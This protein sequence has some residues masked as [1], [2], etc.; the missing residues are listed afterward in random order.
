MEQVSSPKITCDSG[1]RGVVRHNHRRCSH[2]RDH[3]VSLHAVGG[4]HTRLFGGN[5]IHHTGCVWFF[6]CG[7]TL[8]LFGRAG[9][10]GGGPG[11]RQLPFVRFDFSCR[12]AR[13]GA[14]LGVNGVCGQF[15]D[16]SVDR[17][18]RG[19]AAFQGPLAICVARFCLGNARTRGSH[20]RYLCER[21]FRGAISSSAAPDRAS[22]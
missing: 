16:F 17:R 7:R 3:R 10:F 5:H 11:R 8:R 4:P 19:A 21:I 14:V 20:L 22:K 15:S 18:T 9:C 6:L 13:F 2:W 12:T 1:Q